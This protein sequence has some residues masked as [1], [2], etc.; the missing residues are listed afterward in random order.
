MALHKL[1]KLPS[2]HNVRWNSRAI[3]G[4]IA[5]FLLPSWRGQLK[6]LCDFIACTWAK[7]WFSNQHFSEDTYNKLHTAVSELKCSKALKCLAT[8][9]VNERSVLD[10]QR[11]NMLVERAVKKMQELH[12]TCKPDKYLNSKFINTNTN[13]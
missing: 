5:F 7:A 9:W 6:V 4:L 3:Y 8:H 1:E 12:D 13:I 11:S 10:G 2:L